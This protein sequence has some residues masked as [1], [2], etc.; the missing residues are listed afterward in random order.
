MAEKVTLKIMKC[1]TC[2]ASLK[3]KNNTEAIT[4]V[5]CGNSVVPVT[6]PEVP[7]PCS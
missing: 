4:C 5:Y 7:F 1:P 3:A 2:G 6:D